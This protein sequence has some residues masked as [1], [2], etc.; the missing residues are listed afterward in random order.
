MQVIAASILYFLLLH[1]VRSSF[2]FRVFAGAF[3]AGGVLTTI[4]GI[5][6]YLDTGR[7]GTD[8]WGNSNTIGT[9]LQIPI[10]LAL[11]VIVFCSKQR[12]ILAVVVPVFLFLSLGIY[13][14]QSRGAWLGCGVVLAVIGLLGGRRA[15]LIA[16][17]IAVIAL[18]AF[19]LSPP[20]RVKK[21]GLAKLLTMT[22]RA[23]M[24]RR[25]NIWPA[26][27]RMIG[28]RP[29]MGFGLNTYRKVY[30]EQQGI[31]R[32]DY[33]KIDDPKK[34]IG[35]QQAYVNKM[36]GNVHPHNELM[37][38]WT[39]MGMAGVFFYAALFVTVLL[40]YLEFRRLKL[41][42]FAGAVGL[43]VFAWYVGHTAHGFFDCFFFFGHAFA[44]AAIMFGLMFGTL[45]LKKYRIAAEDVGAPDQKNEKSSAAA[46]N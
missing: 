10:A 5:G 2:D 28:E 34:R 25:E 15:A 17:S 44:S 3:I 11:C 35:M 14:S 31:E 4:V 37:Q 42:G 26:A 6:N 18:L 43:A 21:H 7:A 33:S 38:A 20:E 24:K 39:S 16:G 32:P 45:Y 9:F 1:A 22:D 29:L 8:T 41:Q 19:F 40:T 13:F 23:M 12:R 36:R 27:G 30:E 46:K